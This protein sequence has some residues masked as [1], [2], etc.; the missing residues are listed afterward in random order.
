ME[1]YASLLKHISE[2][3]QCKT[4]IEADND[5]VAMMGLGKG[6]GVVFY[7]NEDNNSITTSVLIG[8]PAPDNA[9]YLYDLLCGN[10]MHAISGGSE[11]YERTHW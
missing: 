5:G 10:Y 1:Q 7:G 11:R 8:Q 2:V 9:E 4:I 6:L 3:L